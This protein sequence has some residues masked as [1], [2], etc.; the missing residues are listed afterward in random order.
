M[1]MTDDAVEGTWRWYDTDE[2]PTFFDWGPNQPGHD[3]PE[4]CGIFWAGFGYKWGD[5]WCSA[6]YEPVCEIRL[7]N[8]NIIRITF[9]IITN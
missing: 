4:D 7:L 5:I 3:G 6:L 8:I 2:V 1:G 9:K